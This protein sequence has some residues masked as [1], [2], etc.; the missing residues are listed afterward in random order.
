MA[1]LRWLTVALCVTVFGHA[2]ELTTLDGKKLT[3][4][5]L[6]ING[7]ELT[8]KTPT[9][10]E[11]FLVTTVNNVTVGPA[12]KSPAPGLKFATVE[13]TDGSVL[14]CET[15]TVDG[16]D[17]ELK[18]LAGRTLRVPLTTLF[19]ALKDAGN[20]KIEQDFRTIV[21][22]RGKFDLFV[23]RRKDDTGKDFLDAFSGTF[24]DGDKANES[25]KFTQ[26]GKA[27][28][29]DVKM[30][31][32]EGMVFNQIIAVKVAPTLCRVIDTDGNT[33]AAQAV[34][35]TT[36]GYTV[37]TVT[38]V[39]VDLEE[40]VVSKFDFAAGS[41][42][43]LSDLEPASVLEEGSDP[44]PYQKDRNLDRQPIEL[45]LDPATGK[46]EKYAKGLTI[47]AKTTLTYNVAGQYKTFAA[48]AG[49]DADK[50]N[51]ADSKVKLTIDDGTKVLWTGVIKKGDK[52]V[53]L[54]L[55]IQNV[56]QIRIIVESDGPGLDLGN[57]V[58]LA[59]VRVLK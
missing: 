41:V 26:E 40:N 46:R 52:P 42:K 8:F 12:P 39:A 3:G 44:H 13:L 24:G 14:R 16:K 32:I 9:G 47:H 43:Y 27:D 19:T 25:I 36:K 48:I 2:G 28:P 5:I 6:A 23:F 53:E 50:E 35:R 7:E 18:L 45:V 30:T 55:S 54:N 11:K 37:K 56:D 22:G 15:F 59:N 1:T 17:V 4:D 33:Y 31:R 20:A 10:Q 34:T 49:V 51:V 21:K 57:H 38:G 29:T 58:S